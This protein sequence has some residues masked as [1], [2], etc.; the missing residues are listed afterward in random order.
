MNMDNMDMATTT[1]A[2]DA[3]MTGMSTAPAA[4]T[5]AAMSMSMGGGC[6]ISMLWNWYTVNACFISSTWKVSSEGIFALSCIG[7]ILLVIALELVRRI[8]REYDR[9]ILRHAAIVTS[10]VEE[11]TKIGTIKLAED[12]SGSVSPVQ[13]RAGGLNTASSRF[14]RFLRPFNV[15]PTMIQQMVRGFLY[16]VQFGAA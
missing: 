8:Q 16:M 7:V 2:M 10:C 3:T 5:S 11:N 1:A 12:G 9:H 14:A 6:K 13:N 4:T 15:R